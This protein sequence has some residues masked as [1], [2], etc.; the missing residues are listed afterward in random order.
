MYENLSN[1]QLADKV[2]Q[3]LGLAL[4]SAIRAVESD[5]PDLGRSWA[6]S[7]LQRQ[8][9]HEETQARL[10]QHREALRSVA[11]GA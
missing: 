2:S 6:I 1:P 8:N 11:L 4:D 9:Q 7:I 10:T 3:T 5:D